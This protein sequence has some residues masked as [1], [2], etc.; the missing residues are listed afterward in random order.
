MNKI[1]M[2][3]LA[4][5][6]CMMI[7]ACGGDDNTIEPQSYQIEFPAEGGTKSYTL[8]NEIDEVVGGLVPAEW[9]KVSQEAGSTHSLKLEVTKNTTSLYRRHTMIIKAKN[10]NQLTLNVVQA[11]SANPEDIHNGVS[12]NPAY[13]KGQT[14][15]G[16]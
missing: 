15:L 7:M 4:M 13:V 16:N 9:L 14:Y 2:I 12:N 5:A 1:K 10:G 3:L 8:P 11:C 6:G